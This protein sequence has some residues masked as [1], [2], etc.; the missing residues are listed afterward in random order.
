MCVARRT[1]CHHL[2]VVVV[3]AL[4]PRYGKFLHVNCRRGESSELLGQRVVEGDHDLASIRALIKTGALGHS[5]RG[6][7]WRRAH[8]GGG[9]FRFEA[10][11][12]LQ[13]GS[14]CLLALAVL[15]LL[16]LPLLEVFLQHSQTMEGAHG[17]AADE[18]RT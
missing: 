15:D 4:V 6:G 11:K 13:L 17:N 8:K 16:L 2:K 14:L 1:I 18:C 5:G 7:L 10:L 3:A 9:F 12:T